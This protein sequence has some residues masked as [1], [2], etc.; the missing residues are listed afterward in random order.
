MNLNLTCECPPLRLSNSG[1]ETTSNHRGHRA[2]HL[3]S[4]FHYKWRRLVEPL[5]PYLL[6]GPR[7]GGHSESPESVYSPGLRSFL[8]AAIV[9]QRR[10]LHDPMNDA[11][12]NK[13]RVIEAVFRF[14]QAPAGS[15]PVGS[16]V[17]FPGELRARD[18]GAHPDLSRRLRGGIRVSSPAWLVL[19]ESEDL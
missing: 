17:P 8:A 16:V 6:V 5:L 9:P 18:R 1:A 15:R 19:R 4:A 2:R 10:L 11:S 12:A 14:G 13:I 7:L 3:P